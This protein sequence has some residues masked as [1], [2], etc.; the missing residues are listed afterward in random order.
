[1]GPGRQSVRMYST[2]VSIP[3]LFQRSPSQS[4]SN[5]PTCFSVV[6]RFPLS[7]WQEG[8]VRVRIKP[9]AIERPADD[10]ART[11]QCP[12]CAVFRRPTHRQC[13]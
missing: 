10:S 3:F 2:G 13:A 9:Q 5:F 6:H 11:R 12:S 1:M 8:R 4:R 7:G